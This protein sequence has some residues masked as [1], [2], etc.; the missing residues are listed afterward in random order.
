MNR[1]ILAVPI[2]ML[3]LAAAMGYADPPAD[4]G[5]PADK[6]ALHDGGKRDLAESNRPAAVNDV[7]HGQ[8]VSEC[9]HRANERSLKG[10]DRKDWVEWCE[11]RG[12]RYAYDARRFDGDRS[13]YRRADEKGLSGD[14]RRAW[15]NDCL[16][17]QD[18]ERGEP[19][20]RD[21]LD[22]GKD[23]D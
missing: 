1:N 7:N 11:E 15:I 21:V 23:H 16:A 22:K 5:K 4:K 18:A 20:G 12:S 2:V 14:R 9:N 10:Q 17:K 13:C 19:R 3:V 6:T 8:V